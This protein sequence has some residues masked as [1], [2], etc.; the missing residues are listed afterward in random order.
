[1]TVNKTTKA[2]VANVGILQ[3]IKDEKVTKDAESGSGRDGRCR[4]IRDG[5]GYGHGDG[6]GRKSR[7]IGPGQFRDNRGTGKERG[8]AKAVFTGLCWASLK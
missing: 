8:P 2:V 6:S 1:M 4:R 5:R 3:E 7:G